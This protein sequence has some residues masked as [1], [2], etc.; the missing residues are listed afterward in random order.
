MAATI[1][2]NVEPIEVV[3]ALESGIS[4]DA[5][6]GRITMDGMTHHVTHSVHL[7]R[8]KDDHSLEIVKSWDNIE[9]FWLRDIGVDLTKQTLSRQY[10]PLDQA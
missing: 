9:P 7:G 2:G 10:S 6:E 1:A 8:V 3:K 5:P 4:F